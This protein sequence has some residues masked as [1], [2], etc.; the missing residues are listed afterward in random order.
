MSEYK[1][2]KELDVWKKARLLVKEVYRVTKSF[3][4]E[5]VYGLTS[6]LRRASVSVAANISEGCGRQYKKETIQFLHIARGSLYEIH[7]EIR[8]K[9]ITSNEQ[10]STK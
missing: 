3:P 2:Y 7:R 9:L 6:Q 10:L 4:K 1:T 8:I 5:E